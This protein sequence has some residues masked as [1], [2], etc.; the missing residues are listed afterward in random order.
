[1][2]TQIFDCSGQVKLLV[3]ESYYEYKYLLASEVTLG[4]QQEQSLTPISLMSRFVYKR[5][6]QMEVNLEQYRFN[7]ETRPGMHGQVRS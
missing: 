5:D 7:S 2:R 1:M 3:V 6:D 4:L